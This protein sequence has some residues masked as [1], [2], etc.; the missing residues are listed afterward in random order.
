MR[1]VAFVSRAREEEGGL[2]VWTN[3]IIAR[4]YTNSA[5]L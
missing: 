3:G 4:R 1:R 5:A 2:N